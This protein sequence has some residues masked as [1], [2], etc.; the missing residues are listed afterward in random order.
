MA[1]IADVASLIWLLDLDSSEETSVPAIAQKLR[2]SIGPLN[3]LLNT[4]LYV[5]PTTFEII[6]R[7]NGQEI[8][9]EQIAIFR[10]MYLDY[11]YTKQVKSYLG[12]GGIDSVLSVQQDGHIIRG[13]DR[14]T[15]A[16]SYIEL[17]KLNAQNLKDLLN[18]YKYG[19]GGGSIA[20]QVTGDDVYPGCGPC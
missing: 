11:Y 7:D 12:A 5:D 3:V 10:L 8:T 16:K 1:K 14:N 6:D 13:T 15:T 4:N 9:E 20:K 19:K 17:K 2:F 18:D